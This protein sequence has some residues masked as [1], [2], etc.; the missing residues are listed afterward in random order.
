MD[1]LSEPVRAHLLGVVR[2]MARHE[3]TNSTDIERYQKLIADFKRLTSSGASRGRRYV[4]PDG[5]TTAFWTSA[6]AAWQREAA[7]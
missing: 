7:S 2:E 5:K 4:K 3:R 1:V 6:C